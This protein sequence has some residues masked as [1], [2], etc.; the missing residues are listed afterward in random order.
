MRGNSA[1]EWAADGRGDSR[2]PRNKL[3]SWE[4]K[5]DVHTQ[6]ASAPEFVHDGTR[7]GGVV[8]S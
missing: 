3:E 5:S 2:N 6:G 7:N 8:T 1:G 4:V